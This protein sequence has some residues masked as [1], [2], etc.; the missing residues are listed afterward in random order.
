M[1]SA[2][3]IIKPKSFVDGQNEIR[4]RITYAMPQIYQK[5]GAKIKTLALPFVPLKT[6]A[7]ELSGHVIDGPD[8]GAYLQ[9]SSLSPRGYDYAQIQHE[10]KLHHPLRGTDHYL[11][12]TTTENQSMGVQY[13]ADQIKE[14]GGF[15]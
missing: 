14:V 8:G 1:P 6:N 2:T 11:L 3:F 4:F 5:L 12:K 10:R 9:Y 15:R 7:L 13:L